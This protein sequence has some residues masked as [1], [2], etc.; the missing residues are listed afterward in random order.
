MRPF[1]TVSEAARRLEAE[2]GA[3]VR[4]RHISDLFYQRRLEG[5]PLVGGRRLI[6]RNLLPHIRNLLVERGCVAR[7]PAHAAQ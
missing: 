2:L 4:P 7:E 3:C 1:F 5:C 6:P